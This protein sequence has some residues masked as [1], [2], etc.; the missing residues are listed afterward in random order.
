MMGAL[1]PV[2]TWLKVYSKSEIWTIHISEEWSVDAAVEQ[3]I[4]SGGHTDTLLSLELSGGDMLKILASTITAWMKSTP[5][6]R[7]REL[8]FVKHVD[9]EVITLKADLGIW[10]ES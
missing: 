9:D 6:G 3:W 1:E 10:E 7:R 8:E 5:E 4:A 2:G